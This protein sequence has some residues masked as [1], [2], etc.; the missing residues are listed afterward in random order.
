MLCALFFTLAALAS[1]LKIISPSSYAQT[2]N[3]TIADFGF[4]PYGHTI[5]GDAF[6]SDPY[7]ACSAIN[8]TTFLNHTSVIP[9]FLIILDPKQNTHCFKRQLHLCH[10]S[11]LCIIGRSIDDYRCR[12]S[13]GK[14][15]ANSNDFRS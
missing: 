11:I 14:H 8:Q 15:W 3:F 5:L 12:S 10:K 6:L 9:C 4:I 2:F 13:I 7:D 1:S